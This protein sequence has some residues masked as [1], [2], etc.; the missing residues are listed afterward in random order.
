MAKSADKK[1]T[2]LCQCVSRPSEKPKGPI[3]PFGGNHW[4]RNMG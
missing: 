4:W 3:L 1:K 2:E